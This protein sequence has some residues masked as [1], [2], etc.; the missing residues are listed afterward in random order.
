MSE[1]NIRTTWSLAIFG[2]RWSNNLDQLATSLIDKGHRH[3]DTLTYLSFL[4]SFV[5]RLVDLHVDPPDY[6]QSTIPQ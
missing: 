2:S 1:K 5:L 3:A 4:G 6:L